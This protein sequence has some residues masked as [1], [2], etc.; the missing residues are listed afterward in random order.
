MSGFQNPK[1]WDYIAINAK[2]DI[3]A[4]GWYNSFNGKAFSAEEMSQYVENT[5]KK[6]EPYLITYGG[7]ATAVEIG[8]ASGLT[9]FRL[10]PYFY[11]Y[12]GTDMAK[13]NLKKNMEIIDSRNI[14]NIELIQCQANEIQQIMLGD[15]SETGELGERIYKRNKKLFEKAFEGADIVIINSVCQYFPDY[16]Y[17]EDV[18]LQCL[19][20]IKEGGV[21]YIGDV[22]DE[23]KLNYFKKELAEYQQ[24]NPDKRVNVERKGELWISKDF[25]ISKIKELDS[26]NDIIISDK[27]FHIENELTKYRYDVLI[28]KE[29]I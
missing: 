14:H 8:C 7:S 19:K 23:D 1:M 2:S 15:W 13:I 3:E 29:R 17:L 6:L 28:K 10:A 18:I 26:V 11:R 24:E 27:I 4:G 22:L 16:N 5:C 25:F 9:M 21:L 12:I 20:I